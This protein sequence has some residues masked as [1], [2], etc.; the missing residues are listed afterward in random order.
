MLSV[1]LYNYILQYRYLVGFVRCVCVCVCINNTPRKLIQQAGK[2]Y[3]PQIPFP[4]C[5]QCDIR[6]FQ[7]TEVPL[8]IPFT[9]SLRVPPQAG[10]VIGLQGECHTAQEAFIPLIMPV[11][12]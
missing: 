9:S 1:V 7:V 10:C 2:A 11:S 8:R 4:G 3:F 6:L 5:C 12:S